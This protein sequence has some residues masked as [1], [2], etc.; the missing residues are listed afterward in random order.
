MD[1]H[2]LIKSKG[3]W[4]GTYTGF[5]FYP[6][7]WISYKAGNFDKVYNHE[8]I[9]IRQAKELWVI[10][11]YILY[12]YYYLKSI[13]KDK[14]GHD[15]AYRNIPFE[16]EA[17]SNENDYDYLKTRPRNNWKKYI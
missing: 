7:I 16:M 2:I 10:P 13:F 6:V 17:Y 8:L 9:H 12:G 5:T 14:K 15:H 1:K 4:L 3:L 11:M